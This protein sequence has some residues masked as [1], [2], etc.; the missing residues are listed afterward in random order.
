MPEQALSVPAAGGAVLAARS[1]GDGDPVLLIPGLGATRHVFE[2]ILPALLRHRRVIT[3]DPR[4]VGDSGRGSAT[5]SMELL[6]GD[7]AA[8][9][10]AA[11][12]DSA[13]VVGASM[14][15]VVAQRL[16]VDSPGRVRRLVLAATH[17]PAPHNVPAAPAAMQAL[18]G[19]GAR[20][21]EDAYRVACTVLYSTRFQRTHRGFI[22]EQVRVRATH[23]VPARVFREQMAALRQPSD[24]YGRLPGITAPALVLHGTADLVAP[25]ENARLLVHRIPGARLR[26]FDECGHLFFH[27]RPDETAR[28]VHEFL[29]D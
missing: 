16:A 10:T 20:T 12:L 29:R 11:G 23:P 17:P 25:F 14:G 26:D 8:V 1:D 4:G 21:P 27:E 28:V 13:H 24:L 5:L 19:R 7:A 15:G 18:L 9:I 2:P 22:D 6:A 3:Y